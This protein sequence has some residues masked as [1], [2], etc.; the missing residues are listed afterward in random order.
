MPPTLIYANILGLHA[1]T[2]LVPDVGGSA[3]VS[4]LRIVD[5]AGLADARIA[6]YWATNDMTGL[7]DHVFN[8]IRPPSSKPT[9][10]GPPKPDSSPTP[11]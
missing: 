8:E 10:S 7:R 1:G 11:A 6:D 5:L 9:T 3:L 4:T 2:L